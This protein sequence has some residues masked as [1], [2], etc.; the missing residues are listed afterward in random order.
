TPGSCKK[1]EVPT[2]TAPAAA[3]ASP[4]PPLPPGGVPGT[5]EG[6]NAWRCDDGARQ[7]L[8]EVVRLARKCGVREITTSHLFAAMV[9]GKDPYLRKALTRRGVSPERLAALLEKLLTKIPASKPLNTG[10]D[11]GTVRFSPNAKAILVLSM[12]IAASERRERLSELDMVR[13]LIRH[14]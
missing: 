10:S 9:S 5:P 14:P 12:E 6:P 1:A 2:P 13:G 3:A 11:V 7:V 4:I 8:N